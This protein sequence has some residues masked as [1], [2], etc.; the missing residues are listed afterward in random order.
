MISK[1]NIRYEGVLY[2]INEQNATV[3][4][5]NVRSFG[6]EGREETTVPPSDDVHPFLLFRG[7][8]IKD[9]HVHETATAAPDDPAVIA[10]KESKPETAT[11]ASAP[12]AS[13]TTEAAKPAAAN[14]KPTAAGKANKPRPSTTTAA[15]VGTGA[16]LLSRKERGVVD[17]DGTATPEADFDFQSNLEHFQKEDEEEDEAGDAPELATAYDKDD[18]FDSISNDVGDR[19]AGVDYR[20]RGSKERNLNTETFGAVA[21]DSQRRRR[22]GR[23]GRG[24]RGRGR[25]GGGRGR[26][27]GGR[28]GSQGG[29]GGQ[30]HNSEQRASNRQSVQ[31][32]S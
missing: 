21:L 25:G 3:A 11:P 24:G 2:S 28:R 13:K 27:G 8:D 10:T 23:G 30:R 22:G 7:Q 32:T 9:L 6:T 17:K 26:G 14:K 1:K 20:L 5:K 15:A 31:S 16:S 29:G 19:E 12:S 4:L 18:F